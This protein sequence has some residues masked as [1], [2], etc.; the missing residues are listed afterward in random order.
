MLDNRE[1]SRI[2]VAHYLRK[3]ACPL[4]LKRRPTSDGYSCARLLTLLISGANIQTIC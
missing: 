1:E 2:F 3:V 4:L